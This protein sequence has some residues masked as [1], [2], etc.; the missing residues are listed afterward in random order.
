[1]EAPSRNPGV[2][3][4]LHKGADSALGVP[5]GAKLLSIPKRGRHLIAFACLEVCLISRIVRVGFAFDLDVSL[6][7]RATSEQQMHFTWYAFVVTRFS[8]KDPIV[9]FL[10]LKILLFDSASRLLWMPWPGPFTQTEEDSV[11]RTLENALTHHM[12]MIVSPTSYFG[13]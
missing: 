11:V 8:G 7:G 12:L 9:L 6:N 10:L 5:E 1:M 3:R 13:V 2:I 4:M